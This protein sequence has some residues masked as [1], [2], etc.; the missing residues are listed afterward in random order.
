MSGLA[1]ILCVDDE[2]NVLSAIRRVFIDEDYEVPTATS[3]EDGLRI[4]GGGQEG[5]VRIVRHPHGSEL[6]SLSRRGGVVMA[7]IMED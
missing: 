1:R 3:V 7:A 5:A 6:G 2:P 4:L